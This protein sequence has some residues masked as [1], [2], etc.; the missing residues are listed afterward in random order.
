MRGSTATLTPQAV[1][2]RM[3]STTSSPP[4]CSGATT[5]R[6]IRCR[7]ITAGS[8]ATLPSSL[9]GRSPRSSLSPTRPTIVAFR[10]GLS[11]SLRRTMAVTTASPI[12]STRSG[13]V[14]R[15]AKKRAAARNRIRAEVRITQVGSGCDPP[16]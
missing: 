1:A 11:F 5:T 15:T 9:S 2:S 6:S 4:S 3:M 7:R 12:T 16:E 10:A 8:S 13:S 14:V